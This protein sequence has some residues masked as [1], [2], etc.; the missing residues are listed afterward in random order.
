[1]EKMYRVAFFL[2]PSGGQIIIFPTIFIR[3]ERKATYSWVRN[4][5]A[6]VSNVDEKNRTQCDSQLYNLD[7]IIIMIKM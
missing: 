5:W 3:L 4:L 1:M 7:T 2:L 6:N